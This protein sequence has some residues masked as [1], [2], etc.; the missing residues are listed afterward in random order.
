MDY[1]PL[2]K[3]EQLERAQTSWATPIF[4]QGQAQAHVFLHGWLKYLVHPDIPTM[5]GW[6]IHGRVHHKSGARKVT[7]PS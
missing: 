7:H 5:I 1:C 6:V 3:G 2:F 4:P